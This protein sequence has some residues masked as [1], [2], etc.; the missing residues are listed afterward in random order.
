VIGVVV[1]AGETPTAAPVHDGEWDAAWSVP[2]R[3]QPGLVLLARAG[4]ASRRDAEKM[5][6]SAQPEAAA[7]NTN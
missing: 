2:Q 7:N 4:V 5:N 1:E 6:H 3:G